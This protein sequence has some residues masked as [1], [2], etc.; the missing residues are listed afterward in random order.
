M[1]PRKSWSILFDRRCAL[2]AQDYAKSLRLD[3]SNPHVST[4][5]L[6]ATQIIFDGYA[7]VWKRFGE[8]CDRGIF[9]KNEV[10]SHKLHAGDWTAPPLLEAKALAQF[11]GLIRMDDSEDVLRAIWYILQNVCGERVLTPVLRLD[12]DTGVEEARLMR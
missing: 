5:G 1:S 9:S 12:P 11:K 7:N 6:K 10:L 3:E 2:S 4:Y 8:V